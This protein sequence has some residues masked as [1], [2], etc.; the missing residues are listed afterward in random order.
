MYP[1]N[2]VEERY[3]HKP[4]IVPVPLEDFLKKIKHIYRYDLDPRTGKVKTVIIS[5]YSQHYKHD[6]VYDDPDTG[7]VKYID[8]KDFGV[9]SSGRVYLLDDDKEKALKI[10]KESLEIRAINTY[11]SYLKAQKIRD[12]FAVNYHEGR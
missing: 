6:Y 2:C 5:N 1:C 3:C 11:S 12:L 8:G 4:A 10:I 7:A 9:F